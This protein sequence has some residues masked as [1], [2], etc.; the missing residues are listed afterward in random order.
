M[1]GYEAFHWKRRRFGKYRPGAAW[2]IVERG[3][4]MGRPG[5]D[6]GSIVVSEV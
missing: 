3:E 6:D 4:L 2:W 1:D 5:T